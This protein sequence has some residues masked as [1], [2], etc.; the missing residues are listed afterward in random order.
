MPVN[1]RGLATLRQALQTDGYLLNLEERAERLVVSISATP[2]ACDDCLVPKPL[3]LV[4]IE[5]ALGVP[6]H[7]I[8]LVYPASP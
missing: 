6:Q 8:D 3:M 7:L 5:Q 2:Q 1:E 4:M